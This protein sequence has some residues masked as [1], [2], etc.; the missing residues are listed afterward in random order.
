[1]PD[2]DGEATLSCH[3]TEPLHRQVQLPDPVVL[4][5]GRNENQGRVILVLAPTMKFEYKHTDTFSV[6]LY[7]YI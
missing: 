5:R 2:S 3:V 7:F 1:M 6:P 4:Q